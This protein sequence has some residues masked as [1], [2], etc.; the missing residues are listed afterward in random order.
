MSWGC[1]FNDWCILL[2]SLCYIKWKFFTENTHFMSYFAVVSGKI[3]EELCFQDALFKRKE[4]RKKKEYIYGFQET[5]LHLKVQHP[6]YI[7]S[8]QDWPNSEITLFQ[9]NMYNYVVA[10]KYNRDNKKCIICPIYWNLNAPCIALTIPPLGK[11][12]MKIV[13]C[14]K[15]DSNLNTSSSSLSLLLLSLW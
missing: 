10:P 1:H 6:K 5:E 12:M 2:G 11:S 4:R 9:Q 8:Y 7:L 14:D 15:I 3:E 13:Y